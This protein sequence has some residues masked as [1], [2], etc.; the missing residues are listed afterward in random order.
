MTKAVLKRAA[1]GCA[2]RCWSRFR[3]PTLAEINATL[4]ARMDA[5]LATGRDVAGQTIG[6]RF[7]EETPLFRRVPV[8]FVAE[9]TTIGTVS[10]RALVRLEGA[11]YSVPCRWAGLDLIARIGA[12]TVTIVGREGTRIVHPRK[13][14]GQRSINYR[15]YLPQLA[16]KPQAVRQVLPELLQDL[17]APFSAVWDHFHSAHTPREAARLFAKVLGQ[18]DI[19]GYDVVVPAVEAAL[20][21]GTPVLLALTPGTAAPARL[22]AE[23]VPAALR[24]VEVPSGCAADYDAWLAEAV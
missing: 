3:A 22:A 17:G 12:T 2:G 5:R 15:H 18:L 16:R 23:I 20:R 13:R 9:A 8:A 10:P 19:H 4:L 6:G 7:H 21:S 1:K 14:F 11:V 24:E